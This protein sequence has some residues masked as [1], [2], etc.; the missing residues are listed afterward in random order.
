[1]VAE[2]RKD[3]AVSGIAARIADMTQADKV[4]ARLLT[5]KRLKS[6]TTARAVQIHDGRMMNT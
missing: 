2:A 4:Q 5:G 1:L 6:T 3:A